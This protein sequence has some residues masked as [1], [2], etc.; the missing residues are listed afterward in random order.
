MPGGR[1]GAEVEQGGG[2]DRIPP[3]Y[4]RH[5]GGAVWVPVSAEEPR[6]ALPEVGK[7]ARGEIGGVGAGQVFWLLGSRV[8]VGFVRRLAGRVLRGLAKSQRGHVRPWWDRFQSRAVVGALYACLLCCIICKVA[9]T[10]AARR[11]YDTA[12]PLLQLQHPQ[13]AYG[14]RKSSEQAPP[15]LVERLSRARSAGKRVAL[16]PFGWRKCFD[17]VDRTKLLRLW[18]GKPV[19]L[20][21]LRYPY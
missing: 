18:L 6:A 21:L 7:K 12:G 14:R 1:S 2:G 3:P 5:A 10:I 4:R 20:F 11:L 17:K 8:A 15:E 9:Q 16:F 13:Y 19:C